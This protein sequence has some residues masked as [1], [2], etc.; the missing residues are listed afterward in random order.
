[1]LDTLLS[2]LHS[3]TDNIAAVI[4]D[5][6]FTYGD[7]QDNVSSFANQLNEGEYRIGLLAHR[8]ITYY[9]GVLCCLVTQRTFVPLGVKLPLDRLASIIEQAELDCVLYSPTYEDMAKKLS[10]R[11]PNIKFRCCVPS[12][13]ESSKRD[14]GTIPHCQKSQN[15]A[16]IL[17]TSGSTGTPKGVPIS[18]SNVNAY[19]DFMVEYCE[20][21]PSD[22]CSQI[23]DPTFDLSIH[24]ILVTWLSGACLVVCPESQLFAPGKFAKDNEITSW[25]SVPSTAAIMA[26]LGQLKTNSLPYLK[27]ALFCGEAL[28][29]DLAKKFQQAAPNAKMVNVYG[30]TEATIAC[31]YHEI[32]IEQLGSTLVPIGKPFPHMRFSISHE[33]ELLI[34]GPQVFEGYLNAPDKSRSAILTQDDVRWYRSGDEV[35]VTTD[36]NFLYQARLDDQVKLQGYRIELAEINS[37]ISAYLDNP[38]VYCLATPKQVPTQITAFICGT[39]DKELESRLFNMLKEAL[40]SYMIPKRIIWLESVP[41]NNSGKLDKNALHSILEQ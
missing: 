38:M 27:L 13:I 19:L 36:S 16:Y 21:Q 30:P 22:K 18:R 3:Y 9:A 5:V 31:S 7:V 2:R 11:L 35:S 32:N 24:D 8:E 39:A 26:K 6:S 37:R 12:N 29:S 28:P 25:F 34:S 41:L 10:I 1:M 20:L 17:F 40:P 4:D 15:L 23:F 33:N 14:T